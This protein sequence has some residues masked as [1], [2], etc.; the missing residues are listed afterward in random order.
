MTLND[1]ER[2]SRE[3]CSNDLHCIVVCCYSQTFVRGGQTAGRGMQWRSGYYCRSD[4]LVVIRPA[5]VW[6]RVVVVVVLV[7]V[8]VEW[9]ATARRTSATALQRSRPISSLLSLWRCSQWGTST[10]T[11]LFTVNYVHIVFS[12]KQTTHLDYLLFLCDCLLYR[13]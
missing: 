5:I 4:V 2:A 9:R 13:S 12:H 1:L 10:A 3:L 7:V 6:V 8:T 11:R